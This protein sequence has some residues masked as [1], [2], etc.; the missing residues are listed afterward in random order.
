[1]KI[2]FLYEQGYDILKDFIPKWSVFR[3]RRV[4]TNYVTSG[5]WSTLDS[6]K[7]GELYIR[8]F[9]D[10]MEFWGIV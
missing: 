3:E 8:K 10:V 2:Q 6:L 9:Y 4:V 7:W 5:L 1:M